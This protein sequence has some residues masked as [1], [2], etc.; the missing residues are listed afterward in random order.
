VRT[1]LFFSTIPIAIIA[2]GSRVTITALVTQIKAELAEGFFHEAQGWV[3]FM[4]A[5][6]ILIAWH[7]ILNRTTRFITTRFI[8]ARGAA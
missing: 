8:P 2:N 5:L 7:Q 6:V 1:V 4:F 3:I